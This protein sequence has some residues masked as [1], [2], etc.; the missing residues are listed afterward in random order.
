MDIANECKRVFICTFPT[1]AEALDWK[2]PNNNCGCEEI[3]ALQPSLRI[4]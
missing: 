3:K 2:C 4:D 1:V